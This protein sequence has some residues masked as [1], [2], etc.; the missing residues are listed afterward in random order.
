M[1]NPDK[2][3][4]SQTINLITVFDRAV[5]EFSEEIAVKSR[6]FT[7]SYKEFYNASCHFAAQLNRLG[8]Q[9]GERVGMCLERSAEMVVGIFGILRLGAVYVPTDPTNPPERIITLYKDAEV[10]FVVT[11]SALAGF[12][13]GLG[14]VPVV[15]VIEILA[16]KCISFPDIKP[17]DNAYILFTSGSTGLPKGVMVNHRSVVNMIEYMHD[18]YP[19]SCGEVVLLKS[20]YTFDASVW[21]MFGWMLMGGM[22]YVADA[23]D[24]KDPIR[25]LRLISEQRVNFLLFVPSMLSAFLDYYATTAYKNTHDSLKWVLVGG[26]VV[27][28][29]LVERFYQWFDGEK[30]K[31]INVY[32]PT[33]TTVFATTYLCDPYKKYNKLPIGEAVTN[34]FIY[35]LNDKL[36]AVSPGEEGEICIGG[37]GVANGYLNRPELT[38]EKFVPDP[39]AGVGNMYRTGDIGRQL[40]NGLF[41]YIGRHDFQVKLRGLRIEMGEIEHALQQI[42][43][44]KENIVVFAKDQYGDDCLVAYVKPY[45]FADNAPQNTFYMADPDLVKFINSKLSLFLPLYMLPSEIVICRFFQLTK[46]GKIDRNALLPV[47]E[48]QR[49]SKDYAFVPQSEVGQKV[50]AIWKDVL[51]RKAIAENEEFLAAGGHS[52]KAVQVITSLIKTF[53]CEVPLKDF[54]KGMTLHKMIGLLERSIFTENIGNLEKEE[55]IP[56][57]AIQRIFPLTPVQIEMWVI[58]NFDST[59]LTHNIQ[60]E[61]SLHGNVSIQMFVKYLKQTVQTEEIFRS[62]FPATEGKPYQEVLDT[63]DFEVPAIN[64]SALSLEEKEQRYHDCVAENGNVRFLLDQLP[65]FSF[66]LIQWSSDEYRLL[67]SIHH[68]I[69]DG[70]SLQLFME[71]LRQRCNGLEPEM[72][73]Y[74]NGDYAVWLNKHLAEVALQNEIDFWRHAL[75]G[76]P[77]RLRLPFK[78]D[79]NIREAGKYGRRHWWEICEKTSAQID[80][81]A[82][83]C[84]VTPFVLMMGAYQLVLGTASGQRDVVV[85]TPFANRKHPMVANLLGYYTNMLSLRSVLHENDSVVSYLLRCNE[86]AIGA[87]SNATVPFGKVAR[88]LKKGFKLGTNPIFQAIFVMQNWPHPDGKFPGF[89]LTQREIGNGTSKLDLTLNVEKCANVYSCWLEYDTALFDEEFVIRLSSGIQ[90]ALEAMIGSP[91]QK[92]ESIVNQL[93]SIL[94]PISDF[95]CIIVGEG[96]LPLECINILLR[97]GFSIKSIVSADETLKEVAHQTDIPYYS[98]LNDLSVFEQVDYIFSINNSRVLKKSFT[99]LARI[100][101][102]NYHNSALPRYA[103]MYATNWAILYGEQEHGVSWHEAVDEIDAGDILANQLLPIHPD[104]TALSLNA[105]CFEAAL[106]SFRELIGMIVENRLTPFSQKIEN[107]EYFPLAARPDL[108]GLI[109]P[110]MTAKSVDALIRATNFSSHYANEFTLPL[111]YIQNEYFVVAK[112]SVVFDQTGNPGQIIDFKGNRGFYCSDGLVFP[113]IVY[114]KNGSKANLESILETGN[115]MPI[116][117][118]MLASKALTCFGRIA[119]F[120][121]FWREQLAKASFLSW[122]VVSG[123]SSLPVIKTKLDNDTIIQLEE[124]FPEQKTE[125][126]LSAVL[127]LFFLRFSQQ[128]FGTIG[129]VSGRITEKIIDLEGFFNT[130]VPLNV[131]IDGSDNII[132][133]VVKVLENIKKAEKSETFTRSTR[134]RYPELRKKASDQPEIILSKATTENNFLNNESVAI[135]VGKNEISY[136]LPPGSIY[137]GANSIAESFEMFLHNLI[138]S[139]EKPLKQI[140]LVSIEKSLSITQTINRPVCDPVVLNDV[141]VRFEAI[142]EKFSD[143]TAIFDAGKSYSYFIFS[144]DVKRLSAKMISSGL[145]ADE[146]VAVATGHCYYYFVSI[147]ATLRCGAGFLPI[148]L[149]MPT[150]RT[151]FFLA[152]AGV[153]L[154]LVDGEVHDFPENIPKLDVSE[155]EFYDIDNPPEIKYNPGSIAYIIYTSGS[156]GVPKGVKIPRKALAN[157]ISGALGLYQITN[158]DRVLQFSNLSFDSSIE[159]IFTSFSSGASIYLRTAEMLQADVFLGF[160]H[161]HQISVW[162]LPTAFWQQFI[163]SDVYLN[164]ALPESLRLVIIGGEAVSENDISLWNKREISYS[165]FNTYGPTETTVVALAFEIKAGYKPEKTVP[166][167]QPLPG[168]KLYITDTN[169]QLVP[170]GIAGE[171]LIAG[172]SLALGY[173]NREPDQNKAFIWFETPDNGLQRCYCTG[174]LVSEGKE[175]LI[176]YQG[177]IDA[178]VK[179]RGFR[180]EPGEIE[181]QIC[182]MQG[183]ETCK[184]VVSENASG[185]KSL[186]AFFKGTHEETNAQ[187]IREGLKKKLPAFMLPEK[188]LQ[189]DEIPLTSNGKVN[190]KSLIKAAKEKPI[191]STRE[192]TKPTNETEDFMLGLW[193]KVLSCESLGIDDDFFNL[194]GHSLKAVQLMAEIKKLKGI[195]IPLASLIQHTTVRTFAPL[196]T[197]NDKNKY[198]QCLVPIRPEGTKTPLFLIHG[199]GLNVLL[200]QSLTHHLKDDRPIY[201]FQSKGLDGN[202][203]LS[204]SIEEM[205]NDYIEEIS[206]IQPTGPYLLLGFSLGGFIAFEMAKKLIEKG[207]EVRFTGVID[208]V[209]SM[210]KHLQSPTKLSLFK[211]KTSII[212]PF[213][214]AWLLLKEPKAGKYLLLKNKLKSFRLSFI[215][216][217]IMLGIIKEKRIQTESGQSMVLS[218]SVR[219]TMNE[220]LINYELKPAFIYLDLF[221]AGK[222]TFYIPYRED[223]GWKRFALKGVHVHTLPSEHSLIFAPPND[224]YFASVLNQRLDEIEATHLHS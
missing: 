94:K 28:V 163:R 5:A 187:V 162:D 194:G 18:H 191:E 138:G 64:I 125:D 152:D 73:K 214:A 217:L 145:K 124:L 181:K 15:P 189:V 170:E 92:T 43:E 44:L 149:T 120:E 186:F 58:H 65:L 200:Y 88:H 209:S 208:S 164:K 56:C 144:R 3:S 34:D 199:A 54:Y 206:K 109:T 74:R 168:Y 96:S 166:I 19:I 134:I 87:F 203:K 29:P 204:N 165:L 218:D 160:S 16:V 82:L 45:E 13:K 185:E 1:E 158:K 114:N 106:Q 24:E 32:G 4:S 154:I 161:E 89:T 212:K 30:V 173:L 148:D 101:A 201:A 192:G 110:D 122:P 8:T 33:E 71:R 184:V 77:E 143:K 36:E 84:G 183:V 102:I 93:N 67:M 53:R 69:F 61:F 59:G 38:A 136:H 63:V 213:Y 188:I 112:A 205:A 115:Q 139:P 35:I 150:E 27:P 156:S 103:G 175:G 20:P 81:M 57:G 221:K 105:R 47:S 153:S 21:E 140:G 80:Q 195:S 100:M 37:A 49:S 211:I 10:R 197:S 108:F 177:R 62:V 135:N 127:M 167:G 119:R 222:P 48:L 179:I 72:S 146:V 60:V 111:L 130:W 118:K 132:N 169:R 207:Y 70:W 129:F 216:N 51:G 172:D 219:F 12:V 68:L 66:R 182:L 176:Y 17:T 131:A 6:S 137:T 198:W 7:F 78:P 159:E 113:E 210:A 121:P 86:M 157:F 223:Y 22:L 128:P 39:F 26:E 25:L 171:L 141:T 126:I 46:H 76:I 40:E 41:D 9:Q 11:T 55:I 151:R 31:L 75:A 14:F 142:S 83:Q 123:E 2:P 23:G 180:I 155:I 79:A 90:Y 98:N 116:S 133:E 202:R 224:K 190:E 50:Y 52:L 107:R 178:Q 42:P 85:G 104:D 196:L 91:E 95:S 174:D 97:S 99:S 193:K 117:D 220:A 215:Y 147:M